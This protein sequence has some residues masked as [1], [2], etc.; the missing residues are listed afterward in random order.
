M[1]KSDDLRNNAEALQREADNARAK[2]NEHDVQIAKVTQER[3]FWQAEYR[4]KSEEAAKLAEQSA[5]ASQDEE[6]ERERQNQRRM[7]EAA[8]VISAQPEVR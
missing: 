1:A 8:A 5:Q 6:A 2:V 4:K 7:A 3:E